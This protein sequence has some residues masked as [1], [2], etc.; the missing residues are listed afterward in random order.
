MGQLLGKP[1]VPADHY[2]LAAGTHRA[3]ALA[4]VRGHSDAA[5][6]LAGYVVE[7]SLKAIVGAAGGSAQLY[8]HN[9]AKLSGAGLQLAHHVSHL[10]RYIMPPGP[11]VDDLVQHWRSDLRYR[12]PG[13]VPPQVARRWVG[14]AARVYHSLVQKAILD[15]VVL[16]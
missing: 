10:Q 12:E 5:G 1:V 6:Y 8:Q 13:A 15:G 11:A 4:L 3:A 14:A 7:C 9:L 16:P 2:A